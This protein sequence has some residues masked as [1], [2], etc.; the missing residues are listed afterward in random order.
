MSPVGTAEN[1]VV[2]RDCGG[3]AT[4]PPALSLGYFKSP[5]MGLGKQLL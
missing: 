1:S 5:S 3:L 2:L 4:C